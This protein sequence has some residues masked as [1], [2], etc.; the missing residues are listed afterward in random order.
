VNLILVFFGSYL[1]GSIPFAFLL[2]R[3]SAGVDIRTAASGNVGAFNAFT[4]TKSKWIGTTT[5]VLDGIKGLLAVLLVG[6]IFQWEFWPQA[7]ALAGTLIGHNYPIWLKF[8]GGRGLA[9]AAMGSLAF[10]PAG[11][12]VW[13]LAWLVV[14]KRT[15]DILRGNLAAILATPLVLYVIPS[16]WLAA[17][18]YARCSA[19]DYVVMMSVVSV[20]HFLRHLDVVKEVL[21]KKPMSP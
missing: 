5:G 7:T 13:G 6:W 2:V 21:G 15:K 1:V 14:Y 3:A 4:V 20:I 8:H 10:G 18:I 11:L 17:T 9:T 12:I 19:M 16:D